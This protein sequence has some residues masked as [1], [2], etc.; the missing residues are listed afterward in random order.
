MLYLSNAPLRQDGLGALNYEK[1]APGHNF[2]K[3]Q[4]PLFRSR[5]HPKFQENIYFSIF[6]TYQTQGY[7]PINH[8]PELAYRL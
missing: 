6:C 3:N 5:S 7:R 8:L 4:E 2:L 1:V